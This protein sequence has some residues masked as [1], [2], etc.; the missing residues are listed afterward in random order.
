MQRS[1]F[2]PI[3]HAATPHL[4]GG[5]GLRA[6]ERDRTAA[7]RRE[8]RRRQ[9]IAERTFASLDRLSWA[10][11]RLRGLW[12]VDCEGYMAALAHNVLKL[13]RKLSHGASPPGGVLSAAA[14]VPGASSPRVSVALESLEQSRHFFRQSCLAKTSSQLSVRPAATAGDFLNGSDPDYSHPSENGFITRSPS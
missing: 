6:K 2:L 5:L 14:I 13:V 10:R 3:H 12:K 1:T 7:Y 4:F 9:A 11:S 8:R